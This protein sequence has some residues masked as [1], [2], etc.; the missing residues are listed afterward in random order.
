M[1][2]MTR[3]I[4]APLAAITLGWLT[5][6][7]AP[8]GFGVLPPPDGGYP[9]F[10][11]AE[12][13][14]ALL[15]LTTGAGNTGIGWF[16]LLS[17]TTASFNTGCRRWDACTEYSRRKYCHWGCSAFAEHYR[18][19][20]HSQRNRR[21]CLELGRQLQQCVRRACTTTSLATP[22]RPSA[23]DAVSQQQRQL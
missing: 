15:H 23:F 22:T 21:A 3:I 9:N 4:H 8:N 14:K 19:G 1:K 13:T 2:K 6:Q 7:F 12:G 16:S 17:A 18:D 5:V 20:K 10:T 11:T